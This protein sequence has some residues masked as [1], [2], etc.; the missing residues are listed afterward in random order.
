MESSFTWLDYSERE[1]QK[2]LDVIDLFRERDTRDEL[3]IGVVRDAFADMFFP[4]TSTIQTRARYFLFVPWIYS[5][6][7]RKK[8]G[9]A[10]IASEARKREVALTKAIIGSKDSKGVFGKQAGAGLKRLPSSVYWQGLHTWGIRSFRGSQDR[11]HRSL[12]AFY[13]Y[14]NGGERG[15]DGEPVNGHADQNWHADLP[16]QPEGFLESSS[17]ELRKQDAEY[18][19]ERILTKVPGT[20]LAFLM[21]RGQKVE[22]SDFPWEHPQLGEF[23]HRLRDQLRHARNFSETIH[24]AALL[25]NLMLAEALKIDELEERYREE[26][27]AW[28]TSL[29]NL[30]SE[31]EDW[32]RAEFWEKVGSGGA[33]VAAPARTFVDAWLDTALVPEKAAFVEKNGDAR[34]LIR[35]RELALKRGL[36]RLHSQSAL[37]HW[38]GAAGVAQLGYRWGDARV[39][40]ADILDGLE[41]EDQNA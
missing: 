22:P 36:A 15:D 38:G 4:G 31:L 23:P 33:K 39:I 32:D 41:R 21:D 29:E 10:Q 24:G 17:F 11:Y 1:R 37:E 9:S 5:D 2:M 30:R 28:A 12:N 18:L 6:L 8:V 19:R 20:M 16:P 3:G 34:R 25:Y 35:D 14:G 40:V 7:E 26:L 13:E 27:T